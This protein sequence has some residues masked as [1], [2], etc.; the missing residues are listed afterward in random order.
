MTS[1][2]PPSFV[3]QHPDVVTACPSPHVP[4]HH[5]SIPMR[6]KTRAN[7]LS[8][9]HCL[10]K[11]NRD[12]LG[13]VRISSQEI[14]SFEQMGSTQSVYLLHGLRGNDFSGCSYGEADPRESY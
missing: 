5:N 7:H 2:V 12:I 10:E 11:D 8:V 3:Q 1:K 14:L 13:L 9:A 6:L 4:R